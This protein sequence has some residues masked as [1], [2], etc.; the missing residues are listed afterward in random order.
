MDAWL[1]KILKAVVE[2]SAI[3]LKAYNIRILDESEAL[4]KKA[5][6]KDYTSLDER[7]DLIIY[8]GWVDEGA[9]QVK[10]EEMKVMSFD[11]PIFTEDEIT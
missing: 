3:E 11:T 2:K 7:P 1:V 10:L 5:Q 4:A 6:V 9:K 8:Q